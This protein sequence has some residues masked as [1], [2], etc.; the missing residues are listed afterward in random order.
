MKI[1]ITPARY[2]RVTLC[3]HWL[4][5][6]LVVEQWVGAQVIDDFANGAPR[7]AARSVHISLGLTLGIILIARILWRATRGRKLP[8][9]EQ[10]FLQVIAAATHWVLYALLVAIIPVGMFLVF[11]RGDSYFG[12]FSV[13]AFDAGN[14]IL[15]HNVAELHG[16]L[17]N[18]ILIVAGLHAAAALFHHYVRHDNVLRRMMPGRG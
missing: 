12:L 9:A 15:R 14:K 10:G 17:A 16:L 13:P 18:A 7:V 4:T 5:A 8:P 6:A 1:D 11:V 2:D 3:L